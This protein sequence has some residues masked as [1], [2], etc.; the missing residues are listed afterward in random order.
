M[1]CVDEA[2]N[3][4]SLLDLGHHVQCNRG[5]TGRLRSIDLN[6]PALGYAAQAQ[7]NVQA[8]GTRGN[9]LYI[10]VG[11]GIPQLHH[12]PFAVSLL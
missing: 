5:L 1:L 4:A 11:P 9:G 8:D 10:H 12:G 3:P 2:C 7:R 6:D